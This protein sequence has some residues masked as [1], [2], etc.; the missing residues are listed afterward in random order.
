VIYELLVGTGKPILSQG[1]LSKIL[2]G[3][4]VTGILTL[5]DG[6]PFTVY[7]SYD[8]SNSELD[9]L[10]ADRIAN[11]NLPSGQRT[12]LNWFD[13]APF[14]QPA[15]YQWAQHTPGSRL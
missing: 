15:P 2:G 11:G 13:T 6:L 3:W 9:L 4:T 10:R 8:S 7:P 5:Q 14:V 12:R 1:R